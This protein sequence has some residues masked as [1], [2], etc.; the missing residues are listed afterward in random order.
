[1]FIRTLQDSMSRQPCKG[2][3]PDTERMVLYLTL[4][5]YVYNYVD[6]CDKDSRNLIST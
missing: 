6:R 5:W 1:M 2:G 3:C 4:S